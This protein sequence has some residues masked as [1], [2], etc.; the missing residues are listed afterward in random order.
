MKKIKRIIKVKYPLVKQ[1]DQKDCGPAAL[2]SVLKY[3]EGNSS[4][5]HLRELCNTN[6]QGSTML[7]LVNAAKSLGFKAFGASGKYEDLMKEK[8]PCIAHV[9]ID[10]SFNHF[11]VIY[12]IKSGKVYA[13]DPAKGKYWLRKDEFLYAL[14]ILIWI[15]V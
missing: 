12:K 4:L 9:V 14:V 10:D 11:I 2:L 7:D 6:L 1:Y 5:P 15:T 3:Y 13:A 8:M